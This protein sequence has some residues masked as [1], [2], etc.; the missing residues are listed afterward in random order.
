[1]TADALK[2]RIEAQPFQPF[3]LKLPDGRALPIPHPE[4]ISVGPDRRTTIVWKANSEGGHW[5]V[6]LRLVSDLEVGLDKPS[7]RKSR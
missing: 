7:K 5:V 6:D 1:M 3:R 2:E 4:F